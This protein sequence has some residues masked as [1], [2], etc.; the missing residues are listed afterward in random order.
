MNRK[1]NR[2]RNIIIKSCQFVL[3]LIFE[4]NEKQNKRIYQYETTVL[5]HSD[6]N[7]GLLS[8]YQF[9]Q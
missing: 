3:F 9:H 1:K 4:Q 7:S 8:I 2:N 5:F 6:F